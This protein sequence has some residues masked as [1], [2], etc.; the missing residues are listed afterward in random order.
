MLECAN[1]KHL[2]MGG[3]ACTVELDRLN[4]VQEGSHVTAL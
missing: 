3:V 1:I 4:L 2:Y